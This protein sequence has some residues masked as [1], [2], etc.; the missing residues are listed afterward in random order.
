MAK[1]F[2]ENKGRL[3]RRPIR[4]IILRTHQYNIFARQVRRLM[5]EMGLFCNIRKAR[6]ISEVK[7][8]TVKIDDLVKKDYDNLLHL[9]KILATDVA[10]ILAPNDAAEI[11]IY[12]SAVI[13]HKTK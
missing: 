7:N 6:K 5:N 2:K 10:Y 13:S 4:E 8:T 11:N 3:G 12:L 1:A 9:I